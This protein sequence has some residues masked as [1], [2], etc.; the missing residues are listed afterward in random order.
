MTSIVTSFRKGVSRNDV[1]IKEKRGNH[2]LEMKGL[3]VAFKTRWPHTH[4]LYVATVSAAG[5][6]CLPGLWVCHSQAHP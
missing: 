1:R 6:S 3:R 5:T 2:H 4:C